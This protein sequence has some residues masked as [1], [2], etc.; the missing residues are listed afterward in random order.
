MRDGHVAVEPF[1]GSVP[2]VPEELSAAVAEQIRRLLAAHKVSGYALSKGTGIP[3]SNISRKL[4]GEAPFGIDDVQ[5]ISGFLGVDPADVIAWAQR[6]VR[7]PP[8]V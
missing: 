5:K 7:P 1:S 3:Q 6:G 4:S 2:V 8:I